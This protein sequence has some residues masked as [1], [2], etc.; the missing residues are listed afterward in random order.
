MRRIIAAMTFLAM[1]PSNLV[2]QEMTIVSNPPIGIESTVPAGGDIYSFVRLYTIDGYQL[3]ADTKAG[4]WLLQ[5]SVKHGTKLVPVET[6]KAVKACV[7]YDFSFDAKG[8]CFI[9]DD[10]DGK[11]DRHSGDEV[12]MFRKLKSPV[13]YSQTKIALSR[14]DSFRRSIIYQGATADSLRFSYREFN[15]DMARPAFTEELSVPR[16]T[17]PAMI[18]V[19]NLQLEVLKISGMGLTYRIVKVG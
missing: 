4:H 13:P 9:D 14:E 17:L 11:F 12:T 7:P 2:A 18:M 16:E 1:L 15:D 10:G 6:T 3:D 19:K 5:E 8:P